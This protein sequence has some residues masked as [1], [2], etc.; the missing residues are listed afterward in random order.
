MQMALMWRT[1]Q[2]RTLSWTA[3]TPERPARYE[4][5]VATVADAGPESI[6]VILGAEANV[7]DWDHRNLRC[8]CRGGR[9]DRSMRSV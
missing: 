5:A 9:Q 8:R 4:M 3:F 6:A 2:C 7:G 1:R